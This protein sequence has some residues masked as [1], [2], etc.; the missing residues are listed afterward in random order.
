MQEFELS[1]ALLRA[2]IEE[3]IRLRETAATLG[4]IAERLNDE[5]R[6]ARDTQTIP[7]LSGTVTADAPPEPGSTP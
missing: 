4:A 5:V 7:G 2:L 1:E 6:A 3:N